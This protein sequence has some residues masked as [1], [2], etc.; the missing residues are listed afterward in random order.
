MTYKEAL[1]AGYKN[2]DIKRTRGYI[3]RKTDIYNQPVNIA[4]GRRA[5]ELY[6]EVPAY[7]STRY[8][9]RQYLIKN[10]MK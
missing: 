5:G 6:V 8:H 7:D 9:F 2:G 4:Q 1:N 10:E 3:S